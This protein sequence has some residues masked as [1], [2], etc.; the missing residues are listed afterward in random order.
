MSI[1]L[2]TQ[3]SRKAIEIAREY[4]RKPGLQ[5]IGNGI[6]WELARRV[7]QAVHAKTDQ[8]YPRN[9]TDPA[10]S[11]WGKPD[12]DFIAGYI[13]A[14]ENARITQKRTD[15]ITHFDL[16]AHVAIIVDVLPGNVVTI[17]HQNAP[18]GSKPHGTRFAMDELR[19]K[20]ATFAPELRN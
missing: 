15:S 5:K 17:V 13:M 4:V 12:N 2:E 1:N 20:W 19:G 11:P 14:F 9:A 18:H 10:L 3:V 7:L 8:D 16:P 6:C